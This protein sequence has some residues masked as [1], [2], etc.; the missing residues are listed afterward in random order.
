MN[1]VE[2]LDQK[3]LKESK[4]RPCPVRIGV[5]GLVF[6]FYTYLRMILFTHRMS[7]R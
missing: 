3:E 4:R 1:V 7:G 2:R 5:F 6:A